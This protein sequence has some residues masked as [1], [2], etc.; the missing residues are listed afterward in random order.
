MLECLRNEANFSSQNSID[1]AI[2][3]YKREVDLLTLIYER[4]RA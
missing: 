2:E 3:V 1:K 4:P